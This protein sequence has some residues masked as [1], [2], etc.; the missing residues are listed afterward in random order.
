MLRWGLYC[1]CC[2]TPLHNQRLHQQDISHIQPPS[3]LTF[4]E[5]IKSLSHTHNNRNIV[6]ELTVTHTTQNYWK[7]M[8]NI[9]GFFLLLLCFSTSKSDEECVICLADDNPVTKSNSAS[10]L[11]ICNKKCVHGS[12]MHYTCALDWYNL[13]LI[14]LFVEK[15]SLL[16][17]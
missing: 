3:L 4:V 2:S 9:R 17:D 11:N 13:R 14:V 6:V 12:V 10:Q 7:T 5:V 8:L 1:C 15:N 16:L